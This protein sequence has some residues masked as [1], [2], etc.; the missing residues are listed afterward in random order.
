MRLLFLG[1]KKKSEDG[2]MVEELRVL[3]YMCEEYLRRGGFVRVFFILDFWE[4]Y[5]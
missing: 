2:L 3:C 5:G 4:M 1:V